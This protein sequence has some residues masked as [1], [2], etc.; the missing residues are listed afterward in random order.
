[1]KRIIRFLSVAVILLVALASCEKEV[2]PEL[3]SDKTINALKC[4]VYYDLASWS[5]KQ[6]LDVLSGTYSQEKGAIVYT[7]PDEPDKYNAS[8]LARC[9]LEVSIPATAR[10]VELGA[11]GS[12]IGEGLGGLRSLAGTSSGKTVWFRVIAADGSEKNYQATFKLKQ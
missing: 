4:Y 8:T 6:E 3:S 2:K 9:R 11:D 12:V 5:V 7:F 10:V 1:M